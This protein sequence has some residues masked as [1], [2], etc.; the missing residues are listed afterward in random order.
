MPGG[1][2]IE[3]PSYASSGAS[4]LDLRAALSTPVKLHPRE[5]RRIPTGL[6]VAIP[7]GYEIQIRPR[8]G[9]AL[10]HGIGMV[11]APGTVD[12]DFRGEIGIILINFGDGPFLIQ[13]GD[14]IAQ[15]VVTRVYRAELVE[16]SV[17]DETSRG[18]GGFGHTGVE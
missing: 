17:L 4:G 5:I 10:H 2:D 1:E 8:S 12:S 13:P 18:D 11:N 9:L 16:C 14:R 3:L 15:M 7:E 6:S